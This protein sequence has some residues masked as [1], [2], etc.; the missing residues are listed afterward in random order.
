[1]NESQVQ[2]SNPTQN[3][4]TKTVCAI[5]S[6]S[7]LLLALLAGC[8][9]QEG[10]KEAAERFFTQCTRGKAAD[11]Y[12]SSATMFQLER[13]FKY[14]ETRLKELGLDKIEDM[15]FGTMSRRSN[16]MVV[17]IQFKVTKNPVQPGGSSTLHLN[18]SMFEE[19]GQWR[20]LEVRKES[21]A[22]AA[23]DVFQVKA[24][25]PD[26]ELI[27][28]NRMFTEPV[29]TA[30]PTPEQMQEIVEEALLE[31]NKAVKAADF[32]SLLDFVSERWKFRGKEPKIVNYTGSDPDLIKQ[33]DVNNTANRITKFRLEREFA[34]FVQ[35]KVDLGSIKGK[36][37][38]LV[39]PAA[40]S[41]E[42]V[43]ELRGRY[44][45]FVFAAPDPDSPP[46]PKKMTFK[47][48]FVLEGAKWKL[49]G[50]SIDLN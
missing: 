33:S 28:K 50:I 24:R 47:L 23:E 37:M 34:P 27:T 26:T 14:F 49:F 20:V 12:S 13:S 32:Q 4:R 16:A 15:Q 48:E 8:G 5:R 17:P 40:M 6:L 2:A 36:K 18:V 35:N 30:L 42:G 29:S 11:A 45:T 21:A 38:T 7:L 41:T 44:D 3:L 10:P 31:F 9:N 19:N 25:D 43:L 1:M 39:E 46:I 22:G